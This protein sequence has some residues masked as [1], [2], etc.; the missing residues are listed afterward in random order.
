MLVL[1]KVIGFLPLW[2]LYPIGDL[3]SVVARFIYRRKVVIENLKTVFPEKSDVELKQI[4]HQFYRNFMNIVVEVVKMVSISEKELNKRVK[5]INSEMLEE[6][7]RNNRSIMIFASHFCNWEWAAHAVSLQTSYKLDPVYKVQ[8]NQVL[9]KFMYQIRSLTGG[10]PISK[11]NAVRNI[12]KN[13]DKSRA[14]GFVADQRPF[15]KGAKVWL[16]FLG[17]ETAFFPGALAMPYISQF[18]SY[19]MKVIRVKRGY[20]EIEPVKIGEPKYEKNDPSVIKQYAKEIEKQIRNHPA[21]WLWSHKRWKKTK[22]E[23]FND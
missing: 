11:E 19:Y 16:T 3:L 15:K 9:D 5:L 20:Y 4:R 12:L 23:V 7:Y 6:E 8:A 13:K 10:T 22:E 2:F 14:I 1:F 21:D 18:P 17:K